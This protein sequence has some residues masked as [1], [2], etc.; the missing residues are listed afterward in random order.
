MLIEH[1]M[2]TRI[3]LSPWLAGVFVTPERRRGGI[4]ATLVQRVV[5]EARILSV[6]RLYLY[7][8][9]TE[10]FYAH[11]GWSLCEHTRYRGV[12]VAVMTKEIT[13]KLSK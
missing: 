7:S 4:G 6:P 1:Y 10:Q 8:P 11:L 2:D 12:D 5:E 9:S 13:P 3:E